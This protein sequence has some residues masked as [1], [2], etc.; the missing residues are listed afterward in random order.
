MAGRFDEFLIDSNSDSDEVIHTLEPVKEPQE[1]ASSVAQGLQV[2]ENG[3]S[4]GPVPTPDLHGRDNLRSVA[5]SRESQDSTGAPDQVSS[6][7]PVVPHKESQLAH[8]QVYRLSL[9]TSSISNHSLL[10]DKSSGEIKDDLVI[11]KCVEHRQPPSRAI[12]RRLSPRAAAAAKKRAEMGHLSPSAGSMEVPRRF[13]CNPPVPRSSSISRQPAVPP[14]SHLRDSSFVVVASPEGRQ[15]VHTTLSL[16][17]QEDGITQWVL[18]QGEEDNSPRMIIRPPPTKCSQRAEEYM[19]SKREALGEDARRREAADRR[20]HEEQ[21][22]PYPSSSFYQNHMKDSSAVPQSQWD[23]HSYTGFRCCHRMLKALNAKETSREK[24][25]KLVRTL[26]PIQVV[27]KD[28]DIE[29]ERRGSKDHYLSCHCISHYNNDS[30]REDFLLNR[31]KPLAINDEEYDARCWH[32]LNLL[33]VP[34]AHADIPDLIM[35]DPTTPSTLLLEQGRTQ[36]RNTVAESELSSIHPSASQKASRTWTPLGG[37]WC[38]VDALREDGKPTTARGVKP[39]RRVMRLCGGHPIGAPLSVGT[40]NEPGKSVPVRCYELLFFPQESISPNAV[41]YGA[42]GIT[43]GQVVPPPASSVPLTPRIVINQDGMLSEYRKKLYTSK[44]HNAVLQNQHDDH[45]TFSSS[46]FG[47]DNNN[48]SNTSRF[49]YVTHTIVSVSQTVQFAVELNVILLPFI[50]VMEE[51]GKYLV[52]VPRFCPATTVQ[53]RKIRGLYISFSTH[54]AFIAA[55]KAL[56]WASECNVVDISFREDLCGPWDKGY[57]K[58]RLAATLSPLGSWSS[59]IDTTL[60]CPDDLTRA[61]RVDNE[62]KEEREKHQLV[63][64]SSRGTYQ[65]KCL[66]FMV[67]NLLQ[68]EKASGRAPLSLDD[69]VVEEE[70]GGKKNKKNAIFKDTLPSSKEELARFIDPKLA[71]VVGYIPFGVIRRA[72]SQRTNEVYDVRVIPRGTMKLLPLYSHHTDNSFYSSLQD[73][74]GSEN[75]SNRDD[76][77]NREQLDRDVEAAIIL[78]YISY[79]PFLSPVY[80]VILDKRNYYIFQ[81]PWVSALAM[82]KGQK[83][84]TGKRSHMAHNPQLKHIA[85]N[86]VIMTLKDFIHAILHRQHQQK[87]INRSRT[88]TA[89]VENFEPRLQFAQLLAAELLLLLVA[90]HG[91][92]ILLGP[93][94]PQRILV[95]I[96]TSLLDEDAGV[97]GTG[98]EDTSHREVITSQHIQLFVPDLGINSKAWRYERQQC[99]VLEYLSPLY[100]L[101][102]MRNTEFGTDHAYWTVY[103]DW[104]TFLCLTF[105][106]FA[107]DGSSLLCPTKHNSSSSTPLLSKFSSPGEILDLWK[108][109][110]AASGRQEV[111]DAICEIVHHRILTSVAPPIESWIGAKAEQLELFGTTGPRATQN[112]SNEGKGSSTHISNDPYRGVSLSALYGKTRSPSSRSCSLPREPGEVPPAH[113]ENILEKLPFVFYY[114]ELFDSVLDIF[115]PDTVSGFG[116]A[117][118]SPAVH[119][120]SH[121][122]FRNIPFDAVFDGSWSLPR[123]SQLFFYRY[124]SKSRAEEA[125]CRYR[126]EIFES[127]PITRLSEAPLLLNAS[128]YKH[129]LLGGGGPESLLLITGGG[130]EGSRSQG[131][132]FD[133]D[134][135]NA[136]DNGNFDKSWGRGG[137]GKECAGSTTPE[138]PYDEDGNDEL[139]DFDDQVCRAID[140]EQT[141]KSLQEHG[142]GRRA[143]KGTRPSKSDQ[144]LSEM[145]V[146]QETRKSS[147]DSDDIE[148]TED[149]KEKYVK[150]PPEVEPKVRRHRRKEKKLKSESHSVRENKGTSM[151]VNNSSSY[152]P[153]KAPPCSSYTSSFSSTSYASTSTPLSSFSS[154]IEELPKKFYSSSRDVDNSSTHR[155]PQQY[156][157]GPRRVLEDLKGERGKT[158]SDPTAHVESRNQPTSSAYSSI[159]DPLPHYCLNHNSSSP[160]PLPRHM[161]SSTLRTFHDIE[162]VLNHLGA[163]SQTS[164][165]LG[166]VRSS[167]W[168]NRFVE[169]SIER[170]RSLSANSAIH[171]QK[172]RRRGN[173][174]NCAS[175]GSRSSQSYRY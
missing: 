65:T 49:G 167:V 120:F 99:G 138:H 26:Q 67:L 149:R 30:V 140:E 24:V 71:T 9:K 41:N 27:P 64:H 155:G 135:S 98:G 96:K 15:E 136:N 113:A 108:E 12:P 134:P 83:S 75:E 50:N 58:L 115:L 90:I 4:P 171:R 158:F 32:Y 79:L 170:S 62:K 100:L 13:F 123:R 153:R 21:M 92:G 97:N 161:G 40:S 122:F 80:G 154:E 168:P 70:K 6:N 3:L 56:L 174:R 114:R 169:N 91:K 16:E 145:A 175:Y 69:F 162:H 156:Y 63:S 81:E 43:L 172:E 163:P 1:L 82:E 33:P 130:Q 74:N 166:S 72:V 102:A 52:E 93:C 28:A 105:E 87:G 53:Y 117:I 148:S 95:R 48:N 157:S 51:G 160:Y 132:V 55:Y 39:P 77:R 111:S 159:R 110:L 19:K 164:T 2:Q 147:I 141:V 128:R 151:P 109:V 57:A 8:S 60:W 46:G 47:N 42:E 17:E 10:L 68:S 143:A 131:E 7:H 144:A 29:Q 127:Q 121:P 94:P 66:D 37:I 84:I 31:L 25:E 165:C 125:V 20:L 36:E 85:D 22:C 119:L 107:F 11:P 14:N 150:Q 34:L 133:E 129:S 78:E 137:S 86:T 152:T 124:L 35:D 23:T 38:T 18:R 103:D 89:N 73:Q 112:P 101:E 126:C 106:F 146:Q 44:S 173:C 104:W 118:H 139:G 59:F 116:C 54:K 45:L 76:A 88:M 61:S 5:S 142:V